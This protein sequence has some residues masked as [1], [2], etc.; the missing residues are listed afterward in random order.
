MLKI[1]HEVVRPGKR[2]GDPPINIPVPEELETLPGIPTNQ[3]EVDWYARE[4]PLEQMHIVER[5]ALGWSRSVRDIHGEMREIRK[6]HVSIN[7]K[8][9][10][11]CRSTDDQ[12][13]SVPPGGEDVT[14]LIKEKARELGYLEVGI[15]AYDHRYSYVSLKDWVKFPHA[16]CLAYEQD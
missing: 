3:R 4:Y 7:K 13:P 10:L 2:A 9:V 1:G 8:Q 16:V 15:T 6:E 14:Q 12:E 5:A 11:V